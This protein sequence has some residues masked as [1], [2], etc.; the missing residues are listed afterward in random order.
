MS[1][2]LFPLPLDHLANL[3]LHELD[4]KD[5]FF[6][7]PGSLFRPLIGSGKPNPLGK[8]LFGQALDHPLGVAAGPQ[9]QMAQNIVASWLCGARFIEL[10]TV[11][12]LD[13]LEVSKPCIDMQD[14]GYN[15]EWSQEL[16][17]RQSFEEYLH[18]WVLIHVLHHKL[19]GRGR[20]GM[21]FNMSVGYNLEGI[22]Q[23]NIQWFLQKMKDCREELTAALEVIRPLYPAVDELDIPWRLS[24][25]VTLSTMHGCPADEIGDIARYLLTEQNLHTYVKLN[26]TLLGPTH[27]RE[28]LND[29][30][31]F[32]TRVPD[33]AFAHDLKY[34][35]ACQIIS[36]LSELAGQAGRSFGL[37]LTNTLESE[38]H[39]QAFDSGVD[40][41]YM[42]G[43]ALHPLSVHLAQRLQRDF[44]GR[45]ALSF[46]GG[47]D[48]FN[49]AELLACGFETVTVCS[50]LLKP[51]GYMR[52][53]QYLDNLRTSMEEAVAT[54]LHALIRA[55]AM[56]QGGDDRKSM[57]ECIMRNLDGYARKVTGQAAY[58]NTSLL[59]AD[60]KTTR[61]LHWF[62]CIAA[63][64]RDTCA[65]H[66]DIPEYLHHTSRKEFR[67]A[68][69]V[70]L[71]TNPFPSVTGMVC[72][73]LCQNKC[74][75]I[76]MDAPLLIREVKR[77]ISEQPS[78]D[79]QAAQS[80]GL[81]VSVIGAG[82]AGLSCAWFLA[83]AGCQVDVYEAR[84]QAGGM[85]QFA[86]PGFRLTDEAM[87]R[88]LSRMLDLGVRIHYN[89]RVDKK[90]FGSLRTASDYV[91]VGAGAQLS[92]PL[93]I[94][95]MDAQGVLDPLE[96]LM[97]AKAGETHGMGRHV[98]II[99]GGNTAMDAARTAW[100]LIP[101][102]GS[103]TVVYRRTIREMPADQGEIQAV[104]DEG[105]Q[106][107]E[108]VGPEEVVVEQGRVKALRCSRMMLQEADDSGRPRPVSIPGSTFEVACDTLIPAVGQLTDMDFAAADALTATAGDYATPLA[109]VFMG[110]DA[111]RGA[112]TAIQAIGDGR[113][114]AERILESAGLRH[115]IP[116]PGNGKKY[117]PRELMLKRAQR[118]YPPPIPSLPSEKRRSFQLIQQ[119]MEHSAMVEEAGRCLHCDEL[120]STCVTVCPNLANQ[121][122]AVE[123]RVVQMK[124]AVRDAHGRVDIL[125][126]EPFCVRQP[127]QILHLADWCNECGNCRSFCPTADA[128][129]Q[130]KPKLHLG[131]ESFY[132]AAEGFYLSRLENST[133]LIGKEN[134]GLFTL[135]DKG[136][137]YLFETADALATL[138]K[139][140]FELLDVRFLNGQPGELRLHE[141]AA[142]REILQGATALLGVPAVD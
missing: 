138:G 17:I 43:R 96:C 40:M 37:K 86:I 52:L 131:I 128:P 117:E 34:P 42:S 41:M 32:T 109:G 78:P 14:E 38:N 3:C 4:H 125:P 111:L 61:K 134:G 15:C 97:A 98:V 123:P 7:I 84:T 55:R 6:G 29:R 27:L 64:C 71:R 10:K 130:V 85:V 121:A 36:T 25:N 120:C 54:D 106:I 33:Q 12:T 18:A 124:K 44:G 19:G 122:Y 118:R 60:V 76:Q 103:V 13:E 95:G 136:D 92:A 69:Q 70:I 16:K 89:T 113:K 99:G 129:F 115:D 31:G 28:L 137:H 9:T 65:T 49:L 48:A 116:L 50:D 51:G 132:D 133:H 135:M 93:S 22:M 62:D 140:G 47:A 77:F 75:R 39:R 94:K 114:A 74:T 23:E 2:R 104:L 1:D 105:M 20:P 59:P 56:D 91:F 127:V 83:L 11:Q 108:L 126:D 110:G 66:Q 58:R 81:K 107:M 8:D 141:A 57:E 5:S 101:P 21:I 35:D 82:P 68:H 80:N 100:R 119:T 63:P 112:A 46:S 53:P 73:H 26:P 67:H 139:P 45:L 102:G 72:D 30:L 79:M 87:E 88:D 90:L 142:M 24:D